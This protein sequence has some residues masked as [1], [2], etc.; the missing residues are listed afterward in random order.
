MSKLEPLS[1]RERDAFRYP[2]PM[3]LY[4]YRQHLK[5]RCG[6]FTFMV[7]GEQLP[8]PFCIEERLMELPP[9]DP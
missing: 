1:P 5:G 7:C 2:E 6:G 8:C 4:S 3:W 9:L